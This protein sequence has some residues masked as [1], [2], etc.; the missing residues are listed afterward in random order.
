MI[1]FQNCVYGEGEFS[2]RADFT[3]A[4]HALVAVLGPSGS[5]KSTLMNLVAGFAEP[6]IGNV[7]IDGHNMKSI[8][9]A[10]RPVSMVFQDHNSFAHL[11][12]WQNVT[13]GIAPSLKLDDAQSHEVA[14]SLDA[15]G[16]A[17]LAQRKPGD[18]SGG[19][20]QRIA[21]AR[22]LVRKKP[23]LLLDEAFAALGPGLRKEMLHLVQSL[24]RTRG[25]TTLM[26]THQPED[27]QAIADAVVFVNAGVAVSPV[28]VSTFFQSQDKSVTNYLGT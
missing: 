12:V 15:V 5:G 21:L 28:S 25:L 1:K 13:L 27:A 24:H 20:R 14:Q 23:I 3:V 11:N 22:V 16:I 4:Q 7:L 10:V 18:M 6:Q 8:A 2:L 19:E 9:P 17:H 26:V